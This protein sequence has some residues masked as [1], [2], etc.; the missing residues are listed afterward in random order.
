[1]VGVRAQYFYRASVVEV[2]SAVVR[3]W[4][5]KGGGQRQAL[6]KNWW[7]SVVDKGRDKGGVPRWAAAEME[8]LPVLAGKAG[9]ELA[10]GGR[11]Y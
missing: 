3:L 11:W 9:S 10:E 1:M 5:A 2:V 7:R 8:R 4:E 6:Y